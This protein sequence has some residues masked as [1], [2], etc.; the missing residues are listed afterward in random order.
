MMAEKLA[1]Y[2][3][4]LPSSWTFPSNNGLNSYDYAGYL[5]RR[6]GRVGSRVRDGVADHDNAMNVQDG[7][8]EVNQSN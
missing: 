1:A 4:R 8:R 2:L 3:A 7:L 5:D 6:N